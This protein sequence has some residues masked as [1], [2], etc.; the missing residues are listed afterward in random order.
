M[1]TITT[2]M[3]DR[4]MAATST[5]TVV[6]RRSHVI[7]GVRKG[8]SSVLTL[9]MPT[10][11]ATS[12]LLRKV[13]TL[14]AVPPGQVPTRTTPAR[15]PAS[16]PKILPSANARRGIMVNWAAHPSRM[17]RGRLKTDIKSSIFKVRPMPNITI[18]SNVLIHDVCTHMQLPGT[19]SASAATT[20]TIT[21]IYFP[22][23][24]LIC[25][26]IQPLYL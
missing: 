20:S 16:R 18:I 8:A 4:N 22:I 5:V 1:G 3:M 15:S 19:N 23:R 17:S 26:I 12:P 6:R 7:R 11:S 14:L 24:S 13:M 9:V 21:A 10:E 2:L 25:F